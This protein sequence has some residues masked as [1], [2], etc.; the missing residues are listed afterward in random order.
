M[1]VSTL[2]VDNMSRYLFRESAIEWLKE[3]NFNDEEIEEL[4]EILNGVAKSTGEGFVKLPKDAGIKV[5][6]LV[7]LLDS[8]IGEDGKQL[9]FDE[10]K[11][12]EIPQ[13]AKTHY[14]D[15]IKIEELEGTISKLR[16]IKVG[17]AHSSPRRR[18]S[19]KSERY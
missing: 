1:V 16:K 2:Q 10:H 14:T 4:Q 3:N 6:A 12:I 5:S 17:R 8:I 18:G 15:A 9:C 11:F 7:Y 19:V 13:E